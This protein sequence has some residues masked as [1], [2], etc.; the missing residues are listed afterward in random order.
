[1]VRRR[2]AASMHRRGGTDKEG[3]VLSGHL[4]VLWVTGPLGVIALLL[5]TLLRGGGA[6]LPGKLSNTNP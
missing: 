6:A 4:E 2:G 1:M 3:T 5:Y